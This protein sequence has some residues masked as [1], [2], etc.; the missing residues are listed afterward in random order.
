[1]FIGVSRAIHFDSCSSLP[2]NVSLECS[3]NGSVRVGAVVLISDL[4]VIT[5]CMVDSPREMMVKPLSSQSSMMS[6]VSIHTF[7]SSFGGEANNITSS[8]S[9]IGV[10]SSSMVGGH[11]NAP[12]A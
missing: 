1:M 4:D 7:S 5:K 12:A 3:A 8:G 6:G 10:Q 2:A 9:L 11:D